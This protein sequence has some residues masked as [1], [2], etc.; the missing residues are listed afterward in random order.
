MHVARQIDAYTLADGGRFPRARREPQ[1]TG[2]AP[3]E[4]I[5]REINLH[6][7]G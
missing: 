6:R 1:R 2:G 4:T 7:L 5:V 3:I